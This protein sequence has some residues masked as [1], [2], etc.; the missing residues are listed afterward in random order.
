[1]SAIKQF[2]LFGMVVLAAC[3]C[4]DY[5]TPWTG[6]TVHTYNG[7]QTGVPMDATPFA[8]GD[9][10]GT[11]VTSIGTRWYSFPANADTVYIIGFY[12]TF[13]GT[14]EIIDS[15]SGATVFTMSDSLFV[16]ARTGIWM[17]GASGTFYLHVRDFSFSY[18]GARSFGLSVKK[19]HL[20]IGRVTSP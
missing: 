14:L 4:S 7:A 9:S 16:T 6:F 3:G 12:P 20:I 18:G 19:Y 11:S 1:V 5:F 10:I 13:E 8:V 17:C 2:G 15:A